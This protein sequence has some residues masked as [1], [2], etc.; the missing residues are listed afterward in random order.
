[1][2]AWPAPDVPTVPV[3]GPQVRVHDSSTGDLVE[4][5]PAGGTARMYVCGITP[6][7]A[8]HMGHAAT[9]V[10]FDLLNR[11][12]RSAGHDVR[13]V[14]NV[15]DV[16][17]PLLERAV[18]TGQDW[19]ELAERETEL[20]RTDM[21]ALRVLPPDVYVGAV[22][23]IP[24]V[25]R[26][27]EELREVGAVYDVD[28]DLYFSVA[29]DPTFGAVS[30][31][32]REQMLAIFAERGGDPDRPGKK[33]PLDCLLWQAERPDDPAWQ[34]SLGR[35]RPGWHIECSAI[36]REHLG[37]EFDV[38]GGGSDLV[39][40]HHEMSASEAQV[41]DPAHRFARAYV[42]AGMVALDGEKMSKSKGN[43]ELV[44][45]LRDVRVDPMAIRL[46]LLRHHYRSDWEW[47]Q[48]D[49]DAAVALLER[50]RL[51]TR[52][53]GGADTVQL[54][55]GVLAAMAEDLDAPRAVELVSHWADATLEGDRSEP[56]AG[57]VVRG[58]LDAALGL[59]L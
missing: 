5:V 26:M 17:D 34:S 10:A 18:E 2:R 38:Q 7:D 37:A 8:T 23:S 42:H 28:G 56:A 31:W 59:A 45:R 39:F 15:T 22:E 44:S 20:F 9:Y 36:A 40:P 58:L 11:A 19:T 33:D 41:V 1:M 52:A 53:D 55:T 21:E 46:A 48:A 47:T 50:I 6:Y 27:V 51:A 24:L 13:Y 54:V 30:G 4:L 29:G 32:A 57:D 16:D 49:L 14:Q 25:V 43:L 12:W 35:G 3:R